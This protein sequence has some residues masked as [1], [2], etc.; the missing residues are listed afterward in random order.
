M[1][2]KKLTVLTEAGKQ[3]GFGHI[4]RCLS[5]CR[6]FKD[7]SISIDFIIDGDDSVLSLLDDQSFVLMQW[8]N[9][10]SILQKLEASS[11]ILIDSLRISDDQIRDIEKLDAKIIYIDDEKRRNVLDSG[12]VLDW[13]VLADKKKYFTP[14]KEGITYLLGSKY[15]PLREPFKINHRKVISK[16]IKTAFISF[17]GS[18]VRNL[19]PIVLSTLCKNF[20]NLKKNIIVGPGFENTQAIKSEVDKNTTLIL[21]ASATEMS[22]LM[23]QSDI[24]ISSGG[25]TLYELACLGV[26][27][28]AVLLVENAREDTEGWAEVGAIDYIGDFDDGDLMQKLVRSIK[29]LKDPVKRQNMKSSADRFIGFNGGR[30][31]VDAILNK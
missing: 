17:G 20:P 1:K 16:K 6:Y 7:E 8:L 29:S 21:N 26:P 18:D 19:T 11:F 27:T 14:K 2:I 28:V 4:S 23:Q 31:I 30:L 15:T 10:R 12:F 3:F 25:Q 13:T 9:N 24:A 5:I 22:S